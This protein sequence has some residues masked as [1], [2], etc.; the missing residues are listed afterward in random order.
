MCKYLISWF[1]LCFLEVP[2]LISSNWLRYLILCDIIS[3]SLLPPHADDWMQ[4]WEAFLP[5]HPQWSSCSC[6]CPTAA[7]YPVTWNT[8]FSDPQNQCYLHCQQLQPDDLL[9]WWPDF[10][11][12]GCV[13]P[14]RMFDCTCCGY[15]DFRW[16]FV[17][18]VWYSVLGDAMFKFKS[19]KMIELKKNLIF[20]PP[21]KLVSANYWSNQRNHDYCSS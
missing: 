8:S 11:C 13:T 6:A 19:F 21:I 3:H 5:S 12:C 4:V 16:L 7:C 2:L 18:A 10:S 20:Y 14:S 1:L 15:V 17:E 9:L